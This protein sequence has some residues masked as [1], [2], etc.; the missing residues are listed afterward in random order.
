MASQCGD[1]SYCGAQA[2]GTRASV[3]AVHRL[4]STGSVVVVPW[5]VGSSTPGVEPVSSALAGGFFTPSPAEGSPSAGSFALLLWQHVAYLSILSQCTGHCPLTKM[6]R[7][8]TPL[9]LWVM[10]AGPEACVTFQGGPHLL[11]RHLAT[12]PSSTVTRLSHGGP[13]LSLPCSS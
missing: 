1:F 6:S 10:S 8:P 4:W 13:E 3:A 9:P 2:L 11:L 12:T 5:H 7:T